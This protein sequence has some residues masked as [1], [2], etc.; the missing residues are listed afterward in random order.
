MS[1]VPK[2]TVQTNIRYFAERKNCRAYEVTHKGRHQP[3]KEKVFRI[4]STELCKKV[5]DISSF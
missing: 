5:K 2:E 3:V 4:Q 1:Q